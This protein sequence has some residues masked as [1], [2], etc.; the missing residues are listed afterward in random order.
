[1]NTRRLR[2]LGR[3]SATR[4]QMPLLDRLID[5]A[6]DNPRDP[7]EFGSDSA[8]DLRRSVQRDLEALLNTRRR[9]RSWPDGFSELAQSPLGYGIADFGAGGFNETRERDQ[10]R[11][12]IEQTIRRFEP[13][14]TNIRVALLESKN[15]LEATLHL[16]ISGMLLTDPAPEP[17]AFNTTVDATTTEVVVMPTGGDSA[18]SPSDV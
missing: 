6:P 15:P 3:N 1:M 8:D 4:A 18:S 16:R 10:L 14:M 17:I 13:R 2:E 11:A 7:P 12:R 5:D 9:W